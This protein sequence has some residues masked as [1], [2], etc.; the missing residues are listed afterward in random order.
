VSARSLP[1][2]EL[3]AR[4]DRHAALEAVR[5][6]LVESGGWLLDTHL[7][8]D[9]MASFHIELPATAGPAFARGLSARGLSL[10]PAAAEALAALP[11]DGDVDLAGTI[12]LTF[13]QGTGALCLDV[14]AV[15]G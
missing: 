9:L 1:P 5:D 15:P 11:A 3:V 6:V 7:F 13:A 8:G 14:P 12:S 2:L 10:S 4:G